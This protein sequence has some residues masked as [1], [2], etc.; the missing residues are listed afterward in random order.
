MSNGALDRTTFEAIEA[1]VLERMSVTEREAFELRM[2]TDASLRAEVELEKENIR[3]VELGGLQRALKQVAAEENNTKSTSGWG[4]FKYAAA[5]AVLI[6]GA[7][8]WTMR[9]SPNEALF[10]EYYHAD[11]GL[12]VAM[13]ATNDAAFADAMVSYKEGHFEQAHAAWFKLF[14]QDP[15]NDTLRYYIASADLAQGD[16]R[17]AIPMLESIAQEPNSTFHAKAQWF[18]LLAYVKVD[19]QGKALAVPLD[20][21]PT[22][23]E[24]ARAIKA[25]LK[26]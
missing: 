9:S 1:Y 24:R 5:V 11:P 4:W 12:P 19:D 6:I 22:Y 13:S 2:S 7:L 15:T 3:A 20:Q 10:A 21:D 17:G 8:W 26:P 23:G 25:R 18:L 14:S 16:A